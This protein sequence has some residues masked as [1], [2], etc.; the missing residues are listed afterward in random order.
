MLGDEADIVRRLGRSV[1]LGMGYLAAIIDGHVTWRPWLDHPRVA[2]LIPRSREHF[3]RYAAIPLAPR[4]AT[5]V[6]SGS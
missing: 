2:P 1:K 3:A 5:L 6:G 4:L